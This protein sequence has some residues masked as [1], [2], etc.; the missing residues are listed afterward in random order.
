M[1]PFVIKIPRIKISWKAH[2]DKHLLRGIDDLNK[3]ESSVGADNI[4]SA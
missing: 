1:L 4:D 3:A 2:W